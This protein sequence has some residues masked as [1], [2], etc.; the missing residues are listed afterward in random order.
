ME[1]GYTCEDLFDHVFVSHEVHLAKPD[2]EIYHFA[3][4][5]IGCQAEK[6]YFIDDTLINVEAAKKEGM[7]GTWLDI[8]KEGHLKS[9]L[10][11]FL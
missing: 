10:H 3:T 7:Q 5:T 2:A 9:I 6:C 8:N 1:E 4:Q 11:E